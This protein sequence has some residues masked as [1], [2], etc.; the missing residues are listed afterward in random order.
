M[1]GRQEIR[2]NKH[3]GVNICSAQCFTPLRGSD[4]FIEQ[5]H[6]PFTTLS[7]TT[8]IFCVNIYWNKRRKLQVRNKKTKIK[9]YWIQTFVF[10]VASAF[11]RWNIVVV[12]TRQLTAHER[13]EML[14]ILFLGALRFCLLNWGIPT[15]GKHFM[16]NANFGSLRAYLKWVNRNLNNC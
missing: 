1:R 14:T 6:F 16:R 15:R 10:V 3:S 9:K 12:I 7:W 5:F 8:K 4:S 2:L 11:R 13:E